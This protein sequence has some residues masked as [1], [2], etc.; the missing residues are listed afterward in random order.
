MTYQF[1]LSAKRDNPHEALSV[2]PAQCK[3]ST[4]GSCLYYVTRSSPLLPRSSTRRCL[5]PASPISVLSAG[6]VTTRVLCL[7]TPKHTTPHSCWNSSERLLFG[8]T[9]GQQPAGS[10]SLGRVCL[11]LS[12]PACI[13]AAVITSLAASSSWNG[14]PTKHGAGTVTPPQ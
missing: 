5:F 8:D 9:P 6:G 1:V 14:L 7:S 11:P 12:G 4:N 2:V 3:L 10:S 13:Q